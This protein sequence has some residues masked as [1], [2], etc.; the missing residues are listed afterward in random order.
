MSAPS[1]PDFEQTLRL[2]QGELDAAGLAESHGLLCGL[3]CRETGRDAAYFIE[4]L[5]AMRLVTQP[6]EALRLSLIHI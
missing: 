1:L 5:A 4:Q 6:G 3:A 2:G